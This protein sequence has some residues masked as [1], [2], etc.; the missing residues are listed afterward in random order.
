MRV[1]F[2]FFLSLPPPPVSVVMGRQQLL[3]HTWTRQI[4]Y[5]KSPYPGPWWQLVIA[6]PVA[7]PSVLLGG[8]GIRWTT[9]FSWSLSGQICRVSPQSNR[10]SFV[11]TRNYKQLQAHH[12]KIVVFVASQKINNRRRNFEWT[13]IRVYCTFLILHYVKHF[14]NGQEQGYATKRTS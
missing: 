2:L 1:E 12:Q 5:L 9:L 13:V 7:I 6:L 3:C 11:A 10:R 14:T 4:P 8:N